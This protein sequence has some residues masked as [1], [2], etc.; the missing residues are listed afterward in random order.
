MTSPRIKN[1]YVLSPLQQGL[2]FH[3]LQAPAAGLYVDQLLLDLAARL[4]RDADEDVLIPADGRHLHVA[5]AVGYRKLDRK[6]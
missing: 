6:L 2:L 5:E 1:V 4:S 3:H